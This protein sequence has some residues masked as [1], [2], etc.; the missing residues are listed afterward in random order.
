[1]D[2][3]ARILVLLGG[4][5]TVMGKST[6]QEARKVVSELSLEE[7]EILSGELIHEVKKSA[8]GLEKA[9]SLEAERR[10][11]EIEEGKV[12]TIPGDQVL[13]EARKRLHEVAHQRRH[14]GYWKNRLTDFPE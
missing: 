11:K 12:N 5:E 13:A 9:W 2:G 3:R 6:L 14:P 10:W 8:P 4:E 7:K 1:M